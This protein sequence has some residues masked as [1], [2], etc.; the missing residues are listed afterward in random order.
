[1]KMTNGIENA[2]RELR[3]VEGLEFD[4]VIDAIT[5]EA[6]NNAIRYSL[7]IDR[8]LDD[9]ADAIRFAIEEHHEEV[10]PS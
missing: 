6:I 10:F 7:P 1:M 2:L 8:L 9:Y 4:R 5:H 3:N